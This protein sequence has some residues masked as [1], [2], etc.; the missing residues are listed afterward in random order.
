LATLLVWCVAAPLVAAGFVTSR[1]VWPSLL[2]CR[3]AFLLGFE[4]GRRG[5]A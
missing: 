5:S 4:T 1:W 3:A 2:W